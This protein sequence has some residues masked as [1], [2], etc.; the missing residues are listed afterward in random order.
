[1]TAG[2]TSVEEGESVEQT[3]RTTCIQQINAFIIASLKAD[4]ELT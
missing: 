2:D 1:M 3:F 4:S